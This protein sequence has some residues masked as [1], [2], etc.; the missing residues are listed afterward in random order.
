MT[1]PALLVKK[2]L[3]ENC[4]SWFQADFRQSIVS[5]VETQFPNYALPSEIRSI[6]EC[7]EQIRQ[8]VEATQSEEVDIAG[9]FGDQLA[10]GLGSPSLFKQM[11]LRY[12]RQRAA[13]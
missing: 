1:Q 6:L 7:W 10:G 11:I 5:L 2:K 4:L 8:L 3:L 12:R 13:H 9:F